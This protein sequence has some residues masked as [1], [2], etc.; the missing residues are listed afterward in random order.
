MRHRSVRLFASLAFLGFCA[1]TGHA[2]DDGF[3]KGK[4]IRIV[5]GTSVGGSYGVFSQLAARHLGRY[6]PGNPALVPVSMPGAGGL[7]AL[8]YLA[9]VAPRDG[10][11]ISV[12]HVTI[13]QESLFNAKAK[14]NARDFTW[15]GRMDSLAFVGLASKASG[16]RSLEDARKRTVVAGAP[17]VNNVPAQSPL[18]LN[19]LTGTK[20]RL[21]S[22]YSGIGP[23]F[24]AL[25]RGE[26][27]TSVTSLAGIGS[28][29]AADV[30]S[31]ALIPF[32]VQARK[33]LPQFPNLPAI[34]EFAKTD[35]EK[36]FMNVFTLSSDIGRT[37]AAPPGVPTDRLAILRAAWRKMMDDENFKADAKK[38]GL[39]L[40]PMSGE[41][42]TKL[43]RDATEMDAGMREKVKAFYDQIISSAGK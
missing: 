26:V 37:L 39:D 43:V 19:K 35:V 15:I 33:R 40:D 12:I 4:T 22:G 11:T 21:I 32:F 3:Y 6:I 1:G 38:T 18:I 27:E 17:G 24:L 42:L 25:K 8:N 16:I 20:F 13:V 41:E 34:V 30:R 7:V 36:N 23:T 14:F 31:G 9:N 29:L 2:A 10:T 5:I 28:I